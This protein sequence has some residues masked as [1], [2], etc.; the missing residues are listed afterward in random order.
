MLARI[1]RALNGDAL[2]A[3]VAGIL[4]AAHC[5]TREGGD[6]GPRVMV[7]MACGGLRGAWIHDRA[8]TEARIRRRWPELTD[9]Q[10]QRAGNVIEAKA[11]QAARLDKPQAKRRGWVHDY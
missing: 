11:M 3:E 4:E 8:T 5:N 1:F 9:A 2:P 6:E 7:V 10:V